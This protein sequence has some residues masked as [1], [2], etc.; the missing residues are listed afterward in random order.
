[1]NPPGGELAPL[2]SFSTGDTSQDRRPA[3]PLLHP[4]THQRLRHAD[5]HLLHPH[6]ARG[7]D[8]GPLPPHGER[9]CHEPHLDRRAPRLD[10]RLLRRAVPLHQ[11]ET[12]RDLSGRCRV[13]FAA[14][15]LSRFVLFGSSLSIPI[16]M[17]DIF[18]TQSRLVRL[19]PSPAVTAPCWWSSSPTST[20]AGASADPPREQQWQSKPCQQYNGSDPPC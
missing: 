9:G 5:H 15:F 19:T 16:V 8:L 7:A 6:R 4:R 20:A 10:P 3:H 14:V 2:T 11:G 17:L 12:T 13:S 18:R 1:M